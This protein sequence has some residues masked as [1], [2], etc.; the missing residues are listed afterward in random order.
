MSERR[1]LDPRSGWI[2]MV[3]ELGATVCVKL[4]TSPTDLLARLHRRH[5]DLVADPSQATTLI[6]DEYSFESIGEAPPSATIICLITNRWSPLHWADGG[7]RGPLIRLGAVLGL[8]RETG[9]PTRTLGVFRS[10][11]RPLALVGFDTPAAAAVTVSAL[12]V[13]V[14]GWRRRM[15]ELAV[16]FDSI[17]RLIAP[18]W[19]VIATT[20]NRD[21][22]LHPTGQI[23][24]E[25]S[26]GCTRIRGEPPRYIEREAAI[27][28]LATEAAMLAELSSS[29]IASLVPTVI[30][31]PDQ[32]LAQPGTA[33]PS[34][35]TSVIHGRA[36]RPRQMNDQDIETWTLRAAQLLDEL[37][38]T[39]RIDDGSVIVHGDFWLGNL[40]VDDD[41]IVGV[42]D[43]ESA[44]RGSPAEDREFL[45]R[46]LTDYLGRDQR[47]AHRLENIVNGVWSD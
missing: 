37:Q 38:S 26:E 31:A 20:K 43:W 16:R 34:L 9:R 33:A 46:S 11:I 36:L 7:S 40:L 23:G 30:R 4:R 44:H 6:V 17:G 32:D 28:D 19:L 27:D 41:H 47:F 45:A 29:S 8:L 1:L 39:T 18:G 5:V 10:T 35:V 14:S 42:I 24:Y 12:G 25:Q 15:L 2:E 3:D 13:H 21:V 22:D